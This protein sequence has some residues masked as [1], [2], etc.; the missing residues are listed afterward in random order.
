MKEKKSKELNQERHPERSEN[1]NRKENVS[2]NN[3]NELD[4]SLIRTVNEGTNTG[5]ID[6]TKL[7]RTGSDLDGQVE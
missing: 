6:R 2:S 4:E 7:G 1:V 5:R 3:A